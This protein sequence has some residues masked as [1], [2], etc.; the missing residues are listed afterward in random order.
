MGVYYPQVGATLRVV[1]EDFGNKASIL[2]QDVYTLTVS[3]KRGRVSINSYTQADTFELELDYACFPFDPRCIRSAQVSIHMED[4]GK[5]K[6]DFGRPVQIELRD[7]LPKTALGSL[8]KAGNA[9]IIGFCDDE[10]VTLNDSTRT[11]TFKGRDYTSIFI[12]APWPGK[13]IRKDLGPVDTVIASIIAQLPGAGDIK[14]DNRT[15]IAVLPSLVSLDLGK[16]AGKGN[17]K[18]KENYWDVI[19]RVAAEAALIAYIEL[20]KLV[21]TKPRTLY[22]RNKAVQFFYGKNV[23]E[24]EFSR[25]IGRQKS[26]NIRVSS[27]SVEQKRKI[28]VDIPKE[29]QTLPGSGKEVLI[30]KVAVKG[31]V[32]EKTDEPAPYL[33]FF[34]ADVADISQLI[35]RGEKIYEEIARQQI[36]GKFSTCDFEAKQGDNPLTASCFDLTKL[37]NGTPL[38]IEIDPEDLAFINK[39]SDVNRRTQFLVKRGYALKTA[40]ALAEAFQR[41][42]TPFYTKEV[43]FSWGGD[44][45][46]KIDVD[47]INFIETA[48]LGI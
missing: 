10:S 33:L 36:E 17:P 3:P 13:L 15:G 47:F 32:S 35:A 12:D 26:F 37:R 48:G 24:L 31:G 29:A 45:A 42:D 27:Y 28:S 22:D 38:R 4:L 25:K 23:S 20:D 16:H 41:F 19:Q 7:E 1:W 18:P 21:L 8:G 39:E 14:L 2:A 6:D 34:V 44:N 9:I 40:R 5:L 11:I 46:F 43:S 30:E